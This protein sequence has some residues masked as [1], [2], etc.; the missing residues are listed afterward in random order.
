ML[1]ISLTITHGDSW[2]SCSL[3]L[4]PALHL[5]RVLLRFSLSVYLSGSVYLSVCL[6]LFLLYTKA[7]WFVLTG[8]DTYEVCLNGFSSLNT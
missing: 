8:V 6:N 7:G 3:P 5:P 1:V 4:P 2:S